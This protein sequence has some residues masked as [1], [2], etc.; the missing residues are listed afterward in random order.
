MTSCVLVAKLAVTRYTQGPDWSG[1]GDRQS[2]WSD[3][4][5]PR[6]VIDMGRYTHGALL[7][8]RMLVLNVLIRVKG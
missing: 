7:R 8:S 6:D 4:G 3:G 1:E 5:Q 2:R